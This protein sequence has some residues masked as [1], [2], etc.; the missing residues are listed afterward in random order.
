MNNPISPIQIALNKA[1][2]ALQSTQRLG[3][4]SPAQNNEIEQT[5]A[6]LSTTEPTFLRVMDTTAQQQD[7]INKLEENHPINTQ[8][9][10]L[11]QGFVWTSATAGAYQNPLALKQAIHQGVLALIPAIVPGT[12]AMLIDE[13]N[14][15]NTHLLENLDTLDHWY[16]TEFLGPD[17]LY[18]SDA[19]G[20][21]INRTMLQLDGLLTLADVYLNDELI[22]QSHNAFHAHS[23]DISH[24]IKNINQLAICFKALAPV[25]NAKRPRPKFTTRLTN[26]RNLRYIRT[27]ILGYTPGFSKATKLVGPYRPIRLVCQQ[28]VEVVSA[29]INTK[30]QGDNIGEIGIAVTLKNLSTAAPTSVHLVVTDEAADKTEKFDN[31]RHLHSPRSSE[32]IELEIEH[33]AYHQSTFSLTS[34]LLLENIE[35]YWPHTHGTP[36][37]YCLSLELMLGESLHQIPLG[38]YG[39]KRVDRISVDHFALQINGLPL[40]LRGACW[41]PMN[42]TSL[43]TDADT[44]RER[45][46]MLCDAGVNM[47]RVPGNMLYETDDFYALCDELGILIFQDFAFANLDYPTDDVRFIA[48]IQQEARCFLSKHGAR[49]CLTILA[50]NSEVALQASMMGLTLEH[51]DNAIFD[52]FLPEIVSKLAPHVHYVRSS[53][54]ARGI[55]FHSGNGPSHYHGIGGYKRS[56]EDARLFKGRFASECLAFS[57]VPED[58][59]LRTFFNGE[60]IP[61]HHPLWKDGVARD[62]G[63]GWDFSDITDFYIDQL[64]GINAAQCRAIDQQRYLNYCR[65][66]TFETIERTLSIFRANSAE[67]RA[68]LVWNLHDFKPGAGW[69]YIDTL[70]QPKSA[71]YALKNTSQATTLL[72]V[73]E[74]L[75]GLAIYCV[76]DGNEALNCTL[77]LTLVTDD[78]DV[79]AQHELPQRLA[80]QSIVRI[81]VDAFFNRFVDSSY[82]YRF[83]PRAFHSCVAQLSAESNLPN[84]TKTHHLLSNMHQQNLAHQPKNVIVQKIYTDSSLTHQISSDIGLQAEATFISAGCYEVTI[85][86]DKPAY[87]VVIDVPEYTPSQHYMHVLPG[88]SQTVLITSKNSCAL[89]HGRVRALNA[90][91]SSPIKIA[92]LDNSDYAGKRSRL[93]NND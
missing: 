51:L 79:F 74:G 2:A 45:L 13:K 8:A 52:V 54:S 10:D 3:E 42:P 22:L 75:E 17:W 34:H 58:Q 39:F 21:V 71:F 19:K 67:G 55:P 78:G 60:L 61:P 59:S 41:T 69:G 49:P 37:R 4:I 15:E 82:A 90:K 83:G 7:D 40:Y 48:S 16:Y 63:S 14:A 11:N 36:K 29:L 76:H 38:H 84:L 33:S 81:S 73:D 62:V 32:R 47:L 44:L 89:P 72:F 85:S 53:P 56:F 93:D 46:L 77:T 20:T 86:S 26:S 1:K 28:A 31:L 25:L 87:Y 9:I 57:N 23:I 24:K 30:L 68:A 18:S 5:L 50:G 91:N 64:F 27:P 43:L 6:A 80:A 88:F 65:A 70:G 66:A 12:V 35:A 92:M